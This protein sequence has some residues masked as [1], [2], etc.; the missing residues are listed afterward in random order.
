MKHCDT[1]L[2][3][4]HKKTA[5]LLN[6]NHLCK[7]LNMTCR[8]LFEF[9]SK[10]VR[11]TEDVPNMLKLVGFIYISPNPTTERQATAHTANRKTEEEAFSLF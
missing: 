7:I 8:L 2:T 9:F 10:T 1:E 11:G 3:K 6:H 4:C 5:L